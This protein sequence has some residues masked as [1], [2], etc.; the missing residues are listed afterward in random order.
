[1]KTKELIVGIK[2]LEKG[3]EEFSTTLKALQRGERVKPQG[4]RLNFVSLEAAR[5]FLT[6][7]RID[8]LRVVH[9]QEP[10]SIYELAKSVDRDF[11]NVKDDVEL[12][13]RVGL[14]E[15]EHEHDARERITPR[16]GYDN[17][18]VRFQIAV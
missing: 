5:K 1:M 16:V 17:L 11:K 15:L 9:R 6:P 14:I 4:E 12:L 10:Q 13:A 2:S 18:E 8:L 7:K 3:L